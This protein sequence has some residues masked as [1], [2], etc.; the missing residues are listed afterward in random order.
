MYLR[1]LPQGCAMRYGAAGCKCVNSCIA[2]SAKHGQLND[3]S[4][5]GGV[6][7]FPSPEQ[8]GTLGGLPDLMNPDERR[9]SRRALLRHVALISFGRPPAPHVCQH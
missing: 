5:L 2:T 9:P 1:F 3:G 6:R 8:N 7:Q 4:M